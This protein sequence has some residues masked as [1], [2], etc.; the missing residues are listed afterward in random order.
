MDGLVSAAGSAQQSGSRLWLRV[1][2]WLPY[3]LLALLA[4]LVLATV[5]PHI[6]PLPSTDSSVFLYTAET[7][8][9]G[10]LPYRDVWDHKGPLIYYIDALG[11]LLGDGSRWGVWLLELVFVVGAAWLGYRLLREAFGHY[12]ALFASVVWVA[13]LAGLL[14]RGNLT[15]EY[16]LLFQFGGLW[17]F[18][19]ALRDEDQR[20]YWAVG[21]MSALAF[22]LRPNMVG[23][24]GG[25]ALYLVL[26]YVSQRSQANL[27]PLRLAA[28]GFLIPVALFTLYFGLSGILSD[29]WDQVFYFNFIYTD[30]SWYN[31]G[32]VVLFAFS[33]MGLLGTL[34]LVG[35]INTLASRRN[36]DVPVEPRE[37]LLSAALW[38]LPLE[39]LLVSLSGYKFPHYLMTLLP[40]FALFSAA[41]WHSLLTALPEVQQ[42]VM[43]Y[44]LVAAFLLVPLTNMWPATRSTLRSAAGNGGVPVVDVSSEQGLTQ[45]LNYLQENREADEPVLFLGNH[46]T[47]MWFGD[48]PSPTRFVYQAPFLNER[49]LRPEIA[50]E[51]LQDLQDSQTLVIDVLGSYAFRN[52]IEDNLD[53]VPELLRPIYQYLQDHYEQIEE[54]SLTGW[55]VYEYVGKK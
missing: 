22:L 37:Q 41:L 21:L 31:R 3:G 40:I 45:V 28:G 6:Q 27:R 7:I 5:S 32:E 20:N 52:D 29:V 30:T 53:D 18:W 8:L 14:D 15:E 10:G 9:D 36:G 13:T 2:P 16:G 55:W 43:A 48:Y 46:V 47:L 23:I 35:W 17:F 26:R 33:L 38:A 1:R 44:S 39:L 50:D 12:P 4:L 34:G 54:L 25:I 11:L 19:R 49:Y 51:F 24:S 42:R